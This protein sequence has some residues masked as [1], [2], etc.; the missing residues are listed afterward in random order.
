MAMTVLVLRMLFGVLAQVGCDE[1]A[2]EPTWN[3]LHDWVWK[4]CLVEI[5]MPI[6]ATYTIVQWF[7]RVFKADD[8]AHEM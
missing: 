3:G 4:L 2:V 8:A 5:Y 6:R 7:L 1:G